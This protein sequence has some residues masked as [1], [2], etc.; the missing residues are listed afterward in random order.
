MNNN[1][2][3]TFSRLSKANTILFNIYREAL[4]AQSESDYHSWIKVFN[5]GSKIWQL[6]NYEQS[7]K[8]KQTANDPHTEYKAIQKLI[9]EMQSIM[10]DL[11]LICLEHHLQPLQELE[12]KIVLM[13]RDINSTKAPATI[14]SDFIS[15]MTKQLE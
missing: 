8:L 3:S 4:N 11:K 7:Y 14:D 2:N 6:Y 12:F 5:F 15:T 1:Y 13:I 9:T 10:N